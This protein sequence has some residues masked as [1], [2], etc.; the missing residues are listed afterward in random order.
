MNRISLQKMIGYTVLAVGALV[1]WPNA[2]LA[3]IGVDPVHDL[4]HGFEHPLARAAYI[5]AIAGAFVWWM[6][7]DR[8]MYARNVARFWARISNR[9]K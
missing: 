4:S 1:T 8:G 2:A 3:H 9:S 6:R 5:V 7:R